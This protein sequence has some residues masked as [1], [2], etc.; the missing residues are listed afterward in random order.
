M[1]KW[2]ERSRP[3]VAIVVFA[4]SFAAPQSISFSQDSASQS[5]KSLL[6]RAQL[7]L[8]R[9]DY[10]AAATQFEQAYNWL[11]SFDAAFGA[12][13]SHFKFR[14]FAEAEVWF[15]KACRLNPSSEQGTLL[16]ASS[17]IANRKFNTAA[18]TLRAFITDY[19]QNSAEARRVFER[20]QA[21]LNS[22]DRRSNPPRDAFNREVGW[23]L[24]ALVCFGGF[25]VLMRADDPGLRNTGRGFG[26]IALTAVCMLMPMPVWIWPAGLVWGGYK[27]AQGLRLYRWRRSGFGSKG[28]PRYK[29]AE[30]ASGNGKTSEPTAGKADPAGPDPLAWQFSILGVPTAATY[31]EV[32][33][34]F[35]R[36]ARKYHPDR[37]SA[38]SQQTQRCSERFHKIHDAYEQICDARGWRRMTTND[39]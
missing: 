16:L 18:E 13:F 2:S 12:G 3:R 21:D 9:E 8:A 1:K 29:P 26:I 5:S 31:R 10:E 36:Q 25:L 11:P 20:L 27:C 6:D 38:G 24:L 30:A 14:R 35:R 15:E 37:L 28:Q 19:P 22:G 23:T 4:L 17:Q 32:R 39:E 7:Y 33:S 34:A